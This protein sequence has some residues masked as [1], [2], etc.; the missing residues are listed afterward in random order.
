MLS[1]PASIPASTEVSLVP[2]QPFAP[3]TVNNPSASS[4]SPIWSASAYAGTKPADPTKFGSSNA[5]DIR[6]AV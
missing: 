5:A 2:A 4:T 1:A 3:G 6:P